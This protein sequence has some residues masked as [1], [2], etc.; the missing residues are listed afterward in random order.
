[1]HVDDEDGVLLDAS[2][3]GRLRPLTT[4]SLWGAMARHPLVTLWTV[5]RIHRQAVRLWWRR[6]PF[7]R[8]PAPPPTGLDAVTAPDRA[9]PVSEPSPSHHPSR[10][11]SA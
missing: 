8:R 10:E 3:G 6:T 5:A 7:H 1:M 4:R 11:V 2:Q 9:T